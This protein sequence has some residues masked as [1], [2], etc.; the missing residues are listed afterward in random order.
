[1]TTSGADRARA[2]GIRARRATAERIRAHHQHQALIESRPDGRAATPGPPTRRSVALRANRVMNAGLAV[3]G[4]AMIVVFAYGVYRSA[5]HSFVS[6]STVMVF[7]VLVLVGMGHRLGPG[8]LLVLKVAATTVTLTNSWQ[9]EMVIDRTAGTGALLWVHPR[10]KG[11]APTARGLFLID[12]GAVRSSSR[13]YTFSAERLRRLLTTAGIPVEVVD[14]PTASAAL[15][16][17]VAVARAGQKL[18]R[19]AP[20]PIR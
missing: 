2:E 10:Y 7:A 11:A 1:M 3:F 19:S 6:G 18:A 20:S 8:R 16:E 17:R 15:A 12:G 5:R 4:F 14:A 13:P 9:P